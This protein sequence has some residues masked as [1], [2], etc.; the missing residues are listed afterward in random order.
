MTSLVEQIL[1][2][3][4]MAGSLPFGLLHLST[5]R[6]DSSVLLA[7]ATPILGLA[8]MHLDFP[9]VAATTTKLDVHV[10][11]ANDAQLEVSAVLLSGSLYGLVD[12]EAVGAKL[13]VEMKRA[14][15]EFTQAIYARFLCGLDRLSGTLGRSLR[16]LQE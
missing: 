13:T 11:G 7:S 8:G 2:L 12:L 5:L 14:R 10:A 3:S 4:V 6:L 16:S 1:L 9:G 15:S